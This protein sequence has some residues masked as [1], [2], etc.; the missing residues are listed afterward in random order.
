MTDASSSSAQPPAKL[1]RLE[2]PKYYIRQ[3]QIKEDQGYGIGRTAL[4][5]SWTITSPDVTATLTVQGIPIILSGMDGRHFDC[6]FIRRA[7]RDIL[8]MCSE[9]NML[10]AAEATLFGTQLL[11]VEHY[12]YF[13][14]SFLFDMMF[15]GDLCVTFTPSCSTGPVPERIEVDEECAISEVQLMKRLGDGETLEDIDR[16]NKSEQ[17]VELSVKRIN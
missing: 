1:V 5:K 7:L 11:A 4:V 8:P 13:P 15:T 2:A 3:V 16:N 10:C 17:M 14:T 12:R 9:E 6:A